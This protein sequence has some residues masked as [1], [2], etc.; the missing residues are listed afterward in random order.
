MEL[1]PLSRYILAI[2]VCSMSLLVS[3]AVYSQQVLAAENTELEEIIVTAQKIEQNVQDVPLSVSVVQGELVEEQGAVNITDL[4]GIAPNVILNNVLLMENGGK[5]SIRGIGFFDIDP[6]SDQKTQILVDGIPH[7]RNTGVLYDQVDIQRVEILRGPQGTLFG[8]SSLAGTVNYVSRMAA[9][10]AG[11]SARISAGEYGNS[12]YVLAAETGGMFDNTLRAR[13][14]SSYRQYGG[15]VSNAYNGRKLG[16]LD[17]RNT[18]LRI[19]HEA[20]SAE[21]SLILYRREDNSYGLSVSNQF[22]DPYG[23]ADGDVNLINLD[24]DGLRDSWEYGV[25]VLSEVELDYGYLALLANVHESDFL[26]YVDV[27][28]W[29]GAQI[30][31]PSGISFGPY[32]LGYDFAQE[33]ESFELRY[34]NDESERWNL[35]TGVFLFRENVERLYHRNTG[36]PLSKTQAFADAWKFALARQDTRSRAMFGQ[37]GYAVSDS[38]SLI[39]GARTT[40]EDK[41]AGLFE[42]TPPPS[43]QAPVSRFTP[44]HAWDQPT[45]KFGVEYDPNDSTMFYVTAS[46]GYKPG[47]FNGRAT[48]R[49]NVGPYAAE[50]ATSFEAG[51]KGSLLENRMRFAV[52][53]FFSEYTDI[54]GLVR[55][56]TV[57]GVGTESVNAN[58]GAMSINGLEFESTWLAA[59]GLTI[60]FALGLLDA[61][62]DRYDADLN[63]DGIMTDNSHFQILMAPKLSTYAAMTYSHDWFEGSLRYRLDARYQ[64]GYNTYGRSNADYY[65]RPGTAKI[66]GAVTWTW[67]ESD[68]SIG[69]FGRNLTNR[70]VISQAI[71]ALVPVMKFDSPRMLGVELKLNL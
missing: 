23:L 25:T 39:A 31:A 68:N 14:T 41:S 46:T 52:A 8:R 33:H 2:R 4:N 21:T 70:Q 10:E 24:Q 59:P 47:G 32:N 35:V 45:W 53:G 38:V 54:V 18:R 51:V 26:T 17:S 60:D 28:G 12:R 15:H 13:L 65:F 11:V 16:V 37:V 61:G 36:P 58:I 7:A 43:P 1:G 66:N 69:V 20:E 3:A 9:D 57:T 56:P 34:H 27:D 67:G 49:E 64:S 48:L 42:F 71:V 29:V 40:S 22:E 19:D 44:T 62:W 30:L 6:L 55:R 63:G 50:H 5:F